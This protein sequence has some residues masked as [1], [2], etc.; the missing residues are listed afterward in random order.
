LFLVALIGDDVSNFIDIYEHIFDRRA[1][2]TFRAGAKNVIRSNLP[3]N[4]KSDVSSSQT[5]SR[6]DNHGRR[7]SAERWYLVHTLAGKE[8]P[9]RMQLQIQGFRTFLPQ[10]IRT[11]PHSDQLR[12]VRIS[13][14]PSYVFV[15]FNQHR[16]RWRSIRS[17]AGVASIVGANNV[18]TAA[19]LGLVEAL[20][21]HADDAVGPFS[22]FLAMLDLADEAGRVRLLLEMMGSETSTALPHAGISPAA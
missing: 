4:F 2:A 18:P 3:S 5:T 6:P 14:F 22:D 11:L 7:R 10:Y 16:D 1:P 8:L 15:L 21:A 9:A 19:P 20:M 12:T 13:L 17:L